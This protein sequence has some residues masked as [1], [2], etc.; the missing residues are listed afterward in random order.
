MPQFFIDR[1]FCTGG[2][3]EIRGGDAR[4]I[5]QVLRLRAGDW[6]LLSDG[7]GRSFRAIIRSVSSQSVR[8]EIEEEIR[9]PEAKSPPALALAII[10]GDRFEW[11]LEKAVELGT[12]RIIPFCSARTVP[13]YAAA[14]GARKAERWQ[15][16]A[17]AAAKQSGLPF[18][19]QVDE[20]RSFADLL[21]LSKKFNRA[22]LLYEG[23]KRTSI[24]DLGE[25]GCR[26]SEDI[27]IIGPEGGFTDDE[28]GLATAAGAIAVSLGA[29]IL[30]V[31]TAA[32]AAIAIWQYELGNMNTGS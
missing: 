14:A 13:Q 24:A 6:I 1:K 16:I 11:A 25:K 27:I 31:E 28:V 5:S 9:R 20:P 32:I 4:H 18:R 15:K 23:E 19:P 17:V 30:R 8:A 21:K 7:G 2:E 3:I 10:K 22:V 12:R 29:Q 26:S